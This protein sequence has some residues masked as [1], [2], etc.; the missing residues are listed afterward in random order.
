MLLLCGWMVATVSGRNFSGQ[1]ND[2]KPLSSDSEA[3]RQVLRNKHL[4]AFW[5]F[6]QEEGVAKRDKSK[7]GFILQEHGNCPIAVVDEG[8]LSGRSVRLDG[9]SYF[10]IPYRQSGKLNVKTNEVTVIAWVK[11]SGEQTGFVAGMWN[12]Y[13]DGGKRQYG[14][15]V[16]LPHYNGK[17][18]VC[19]HIS[20]SGKATPPFP[21]SIDY[22]ASQQEVP[23]DKWCCIAFSYDGTYIRS[24][25]DGICIPRDPE[26][27][28]HTKG[29]EGYPDGLVQSKNPYYFPDGIGDNGSDFT[30]GAVSLKN[31]MGNFFTGC[32][33]GV[34]VYDRALPADEIAKISQLFTSP[35][36]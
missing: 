27:I 21:Y 14:L 6:S 34:A 16:S 1:G 28:Y 13:Q 35:G 11:W 19:G 25:L 33:G 20:Q 8:P 30:I 26:L 2:N 12:E 32:I 17:N 23:P 18:Q 22:S 7:N 29:F 15:F 24:Y 3:V 9:E 5:D 10:S 31:G 4:V 36:Q